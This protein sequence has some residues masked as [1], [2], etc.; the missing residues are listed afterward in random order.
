MLKDLTRLKDHLPSRASAEK[1]P[2]GERGA[3]KK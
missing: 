3:G 2:G 1:T